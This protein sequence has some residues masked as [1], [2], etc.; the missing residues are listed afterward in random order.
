MGAGDDEGYNGQQRGKAKP[1]QIA[2]YAM[3]NL[4]AVPLFIPWR[5]IGSTLRPLNG[6]AH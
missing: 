5:F 4:P 1:G 3:L 2:Q 6:L